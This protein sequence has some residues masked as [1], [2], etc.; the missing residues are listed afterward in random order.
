MMTQKRIIELLALLMIGDGVA[1]FIKPHWHSLLWNMGPRSFRSLMQNLAG[2]PQ[3]AR[4]LYGAEV[5]LG[6]WL[7]M[8]DTAEQ[9]NLF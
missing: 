7:A 5:A 8:R 6:T 4:L 3:E 2:H 1:G 9:P